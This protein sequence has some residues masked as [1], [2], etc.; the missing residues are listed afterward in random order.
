MDVCYGYR[1]GDNDMQDDL[2]YRQAALEALE[3]L[4]PVFP[5]KS[6]FTQ[7]ITCGIALAKVCI[8]KQVSAAEPERKTGRWVGNPETCE[9]MTC[10]A[11]GCEFDW[12]SEGGYSSNE[13]A[14]C[15]EC[16]ADMGGE[17][18]EAD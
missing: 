13:W 5:M 4:F 10:S 9:F 15:P 3:K 2:I 18:N 17:Q 8:G 12:V 16:G 1:S 6:D 14:Y 11:C 7:G